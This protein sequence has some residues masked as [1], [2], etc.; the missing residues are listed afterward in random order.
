MMRKI[1]YHEYKYCLLERLITKLANYVQRQRAKIQSV[2]C[3]LHA[4]SRLHI[5]AIHLDLTSY[6]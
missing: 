4:V 3:L 6:T 1:K 5:G 2:F